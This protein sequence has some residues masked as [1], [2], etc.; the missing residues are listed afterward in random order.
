MLILHTLY[1]HYRLTGGWLEVF[2][3]KVLVHDVIDTHPDI[4]KRVRK[5]K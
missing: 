4:L 5:A 1:S 2:L 3:V